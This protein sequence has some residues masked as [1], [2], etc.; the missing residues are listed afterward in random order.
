MR[1]PK[2]QKIQLDCLLG[3]GI[4]TAMTCIVRTVFSYEIKQPD[5]TWQGVPNAICRMLEVNFGIIAACMPMMRTLLISMKKRRQSRGSERLTSSHI[6][7]SQLQWYNP[8]TERPWYSRIKR[9]L[10]QPHP[11]TDMISDLHASDSDRS[12]TRPYKGNE[13]VPKPPILRRRS[14]SWPIPK[15][16]ILRRR[17]SSRPIPQTHPPLNRGKSPKY[18]ERPENATWAENRTLSEVDSID[19]P[20]QGARHRDWD[21]Q[22]EDEK[23][24]EQDPGSG[25]KRYHRHWV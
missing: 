18:D 9:S 11:T 13:Q 6:P 5:I 24:S 7:A 19:L 1:L 20:I 22:E 21:D 10:W 3:L 15:P 8:P 12:P 25:T 16:P 23:G 2:R 4:V 17:S 14:T